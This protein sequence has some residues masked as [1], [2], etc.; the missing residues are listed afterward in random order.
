LAAAAQIPTPILTRRKS[1]SPSSGASTINIPIS[2]DLGFAGVNQPIC[3][4]VQESLQQIGITTTIKQ[5][6]G[7]EL[8]HRAHQKGR[9]RCSPTYS[10]GWLDY[11]EYF[12]YW[13]YHSGKSIFKHDG[14]SVAADGYLHRWRALRCGDRA[15]GTPQQGVK[16][17]CRSGL[18]RHATHPA[19]SALRQRCDAENIAAMILVPPAVDYRSFAKGNPITVMPAWLL[20]VHPSLRSPGAGRPRPSTRVRRSRR[21]WPEQV[22]PWT[23]K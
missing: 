13:S 1:F 22:L 15:I 4:L 23:T 14:L 11:P 21:G 18:H 8:A 10:P 12:F 16:G 17:L 19:L 7:G 9:C 2:F 3:E 6:A 5:G 20:E